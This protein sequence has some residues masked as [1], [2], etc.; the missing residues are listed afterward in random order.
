[1]DAFE[2]SSADST[3]HET[4][5]RSKDDG[6]SYYRHLLNREKRQ[7]SH[8]KKEHQRGLSRRAKA[9]FS[10]SPFAA[11]LMSQS[12]KRETMAMLQ[13]QAKPKRH[14]KLLQPPKKRTDSTLKKLRLELRHWQEVEKRIRG[15]ISSERP[16]ASTRRTKSYTLHFLANKSG[17]EEP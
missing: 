4:D 8:Q 13:R 17:V 5:E 11:N 16:A 1:M 2:S 6:S 10:Q 7:D 3:L 15:A 9:R 14:K 12:E